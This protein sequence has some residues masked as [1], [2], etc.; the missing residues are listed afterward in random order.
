M[1]RYS[2]TDCSTSRPCPTFEDTCIGNDH[3]TTD[4]ADQPSTNPHHDPLVPDADTALRPASADPQGGLDYGDLDE[5]QAQALQT[6]SARRVL[7]KDMSMDDSTSTPE[8]TAAAT[9]PIP[10]P[11]AS[12][13]P[14]GTYQ[15]S[16]IKR[17]RATKAQVEGR[18]DELF[19]IVEKMQPMTVRGVY[20]QATV[21]KLVEKTLSGYTK[22]QTDLTRMRRAGELPYDWI[23]DGTRRPLKARSFG[24]VYELLDDTVQ[25][26]KKALWTDAN[27]YVEIWVEKDAL[28]GVLLPVTIE[29]DV[30]LMVSRG[31][32]SISFLYNAAEYM[33]Q[34]E[35][36]VFIYHLGDYDPSGVDAAEAIE[37]ELQQMAPWTIIS[38]KRLAVTSEQII[39]W[40]L[41]TRETN[42]KDTRAKNFVGGDV[43]VEL[44]SID[45]NTLRDMVRDAIEQRLPA[46]KLAAMNAEEDSEREL[47]EDII[48]DAKIYRSGIS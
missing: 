22:V 48:R 17:H 23:T 43:S 36:P 10:P 25:S 41:P 6:A 35:V 46:D 13:G 29:Y 42:K 21:R 32:S 16:K 5:N 12:L 44:D 45:P 8:P 19:D 38:F 47:L 37:H 24:S 1:P 33:K 2:N 11:P 34:L 27:C 15:A 4:G 20:Y 7:I 31:Y 30:P 26:Y 9:P 14:N 3:F 28:S 39:E 18:R 40:D